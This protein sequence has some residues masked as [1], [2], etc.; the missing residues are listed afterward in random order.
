MRYYRRVQTKDL[1]KKTEAKSLSPDANLPFA[2]S[3]NYS[4]SI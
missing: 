1:R 4:R 3:F 2:G